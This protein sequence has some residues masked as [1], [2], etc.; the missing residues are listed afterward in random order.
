MPELFPEGPEHGAE[1]EHLLDL[2]FGEDRRRKVSYRYRPGIPPIARLCLVAREG[3]RLV[4]AI[5]YWPMLLGGENVLLL[6]PLAIDPELRGQGIGRA[7]IRASLA[8]AEAM[9]Y[10]LVFLVGDP[11]YYAQHGFA[12]VPP[13]IRMP[14]ESPGR[15]QYIALGG[16]ELPPDGGELL[17][18]DGSSI[19]G[20]PVEP[21]QER[22]PDPGQGLVGGHAGLHLAQPGGQGRGHGRIGRHARQRPDEG[23]DREQHGQ[24]PRQPPQ[25]L[26]LDPPPQLL[27]GILG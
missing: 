7:L 10:R 25:R 20:L 27:A 5:R 15:V 11:A 18:A 12:V 4:G 24:G 8:E 9:G 2:S 16:A 19:A 14:D 3:G 6:G 1:I 26:A 17:R 22:L 21:A 13:S 23:A